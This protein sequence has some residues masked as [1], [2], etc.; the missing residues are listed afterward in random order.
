MKK[1]LIII[2][3]YFCVTS[4]L[5]QSPD[6]ISYQSVVRDVNSQLVINQ[7]ISLQ[8]SILQGSQ[9]GVAVYEE[10]HLSA[11]NKDGFVF[12]EIGTGMSSS[13]LNDVDWNDGPFFI[14]VEIDVNA[15]ANYTIAGVSQLLSV[16]YAFHASTADSLTAPIV[17]N[18]PVF[19]N[20]AAYNISQQNIDRWD[21]LALMS[22]DLNG[23]RLRNIG[24]PVEKQDAATKHY[25][26]I[27][28][29]QLAALNSVLLESGMYGVVSTVDG[30][31]YKTI[32][33]GS[34]IWMAENLKT[35]VFNDG[36]P[37]AYPGNDITQWRDDTVGA[38]A[39]YGNDVSNK[40]K[41]GALYN[42]N[43]VKT[44]KLCPKGWHVSTDDDWK[45]LEKTLG[46]SSSYIKRTSWRGGT[47]GLRIMTFARTKTVVVGGNRYGP[48]TAITENSSKFSAVGGGFR[49][50]DG[51]YAGTLSRYGAWWSAGSRNYRR[52]LDYKRHQ[53]Y[54]GEIDSRS[55]LSVR[56][57]K[58]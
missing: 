3:A 32:K 57:L 49:E 17:E 48:G 20:S 41:Y 52:V 42:V 35:T 44:G 8:I 11:T 16:P 2:V 21:S 27:L 14:K 10:R 46:M 26:D 34:Q 36:T 54:R 28:T 19:H 25:V 13:R 12:V 51:R 50:F 40:D 18:D 29:N 33:I 45:T 38:Y 1:L 4:I 53:I 30:T 37:I 47:E 22:T 23:E 15:G 6:K 24:E 5:A 58:D 39:W 7:T 9:Y 43:A 55:G 31:V 56:C